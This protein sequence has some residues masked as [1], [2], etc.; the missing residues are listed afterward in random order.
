MLPSFIIYRKTT[1]EFCMKIAICQTGVA[2]YSLQFFST[3]TNQHVL[4]H[5]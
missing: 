4:G 5:W 2:L 1:E 3:L